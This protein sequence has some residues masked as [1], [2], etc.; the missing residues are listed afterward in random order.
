MKRLFPFMARRK[1]S[2]RKFNLRRVR[3]SSNMVIG[4]LASQDVV[5]GDFTVISSNSYRL[6]S[7]NCAW[8][9]VDLAAF[10][11]DGQEFGV[12][13]SDYSAAEIEECL[14][15]QTS[16]DPSNK[17]ENEQ[18][19]RLVRTIGMM[20][21]DPG[22]DAGMTFNDGRPVKTKL[23][24]K[25]GIG[26]KVRMWVRNGSQNVYT[27]GSQLTAIGDIWVRDGF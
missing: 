5:D 11:D 3:I 20:P 8:S 26:D 6:I 18:A 16:I 15:A 22:T 23:N 13:H 21:G 17:I 1:R 19:N 27:T 9:I 10:I 4:A 12:A 25:M 7:L 24:W 14:E 2:R